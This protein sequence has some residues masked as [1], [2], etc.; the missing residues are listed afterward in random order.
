ML[1]DDSIAPRPVAPWVAAGSGALMLGGGVAAHYGYPRNV[2]VASPGV[3]SSRG[4]GVL[5]YVPLAMPWALKAAG[6]HT[7]SG[8]G[9]MA[10]SQAFGVGIMAGSVKLIKNG[11]SSL[12]PDGSDYHSFPSGHTAWAFMG[13]TVMAIEL[14]EQ[15]PW[16]ALGGYTLATAIAVERVMDAHHYPA[17]VMAGAGIGM[18]SAQLG[19]LI[20]DLICGRP[21][22]SLTGH[23]I[24][25]R[26]NYSYL[27]VATGLSMPLGC[28]RAGG[29][30]IQRLPALVTALRG[31][32][33]I[34]DH[35]GLGLELG[36]TST[37]LITD[38]AH[39]RT[40]V[41]SQCSVGVSVVPYYNLS[42]SRRV[43]LQAEAGVGYRH[44]L[45]LNLDDA[46]AITIGTSSPV[47]RVGVGCVVKMNSHF[48]ARAQVGYEMS[49]YRYTVRPSADYHITEAASARGV[50]SAILVSLSSRYEF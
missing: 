39:D 44:N 40:F 50:G 11:V 31:G 46:D 49:R 42:L 30:V 6:V 27:S 45:P 19:Y 36:V 26:G 8:W 48:S 16:Y 28:V 29:T 12:R 21:A 10:V 35:W 41:K 15:S 17:D 4:T 2:E 1:G 34:D 32:W 9:Q 22:G 47:G 13:A 37:P 25:P 14:A 33:A 43:S 20:G 38:V 3:R 5:Q 24:S 23:D 18:L 7:R